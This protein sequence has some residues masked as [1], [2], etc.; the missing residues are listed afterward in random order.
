[1][2]QI[3]L[4]NKLENMLF[5]NMLIKWQNR[6]YLAAYFILK[7]FLLNLHDPCMPLYE[8]TKLALVFIFMY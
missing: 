3:I 1:M 4:L 2:L 6:C 8:L 7:L 5:V